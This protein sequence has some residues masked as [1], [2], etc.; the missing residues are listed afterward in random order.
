MLEKAQ[1]LLMT[2]AGSALGQD[3]AVCNIKGRKQCRGAMSD[4]AVGDALDITQP[5]RQ[6]RLGTLERMNLAI[7]VDA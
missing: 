1:E 3:L 4:I 5:K 6:N 2:M 7:F